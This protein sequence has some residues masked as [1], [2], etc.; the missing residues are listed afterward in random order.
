MPGAFDL[1][2]DVYFTVQHDRRRILALTGGGGLELR[3]S[4]KQ[5]DLTASIP[6]TTDGRDARELLRRANA[7]GP[8]GRNEDSARR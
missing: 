2:R 8:I 4:P 7:P 6:G 5:L 1:K 3:D